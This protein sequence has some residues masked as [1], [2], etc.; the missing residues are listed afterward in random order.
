MTPG[1][2]QGP[3][4]AQGS[5][6]AKVRDGDDKEAADAEQRRRWGG[7]K[8]CNEWRGL[9]DVGHHHG[10]LTL[11]FLIR[12]GSTSHSRC[13]LCLFPL[14]WFSSPMTSPFPFRLP[15]PTAP[16]H[17][18]HARTHDSCPRWETRSPLLAHPPAHKGGPK[19]ARFALQSLQSLRWTPLHSSISGWRNRCEQSQKGEQK[20][21]PSPPQ[22]PS[23]NHILLPT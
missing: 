14:L 3:A 18:H 22:L 7:S 4:G 8:T 1:K 10:S 2:E 11:P 16:V 17:L 9:G 12:P 6:K 15:Q 13:L 21:F 5:R 23:Q 20:Q 19:K